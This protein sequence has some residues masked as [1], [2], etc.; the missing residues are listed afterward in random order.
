M[1]TSSV[2][3]SAALPVTSMTSN[4]PAPLPS[5]S[6]ATADWGV[7][8]RSPSMVSVPGDAPGLSVPALVSVPTANVPLP[9]IVPLLA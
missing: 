1:A 4:W 5:I 3:S 6:M 8:T 9:R 7:S 2:P